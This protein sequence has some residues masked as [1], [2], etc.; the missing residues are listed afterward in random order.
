MYLG[1]HV[2]KPTDSHLDNYLCVAWPCSVMW[3]DWTESGIR[4][5]AT[6]RQ[7]FYDKFGRWPIVVGRD[8]ER[9][10]NVLDPQFAINCIRERDSQVGNL[11]D[12][13]QV[14][15]EPAAT[16]P[17]ELKAINDFYCKVIDGLPASCSPI[18]VGSLG[19]GN[20]RNII[21]IQLLEPAI[22]KAIATG[23]GFA[24]HEY[25]Q[26]RMDNEA[27]W[28][29]GRLLKTLD[30]LSIWIDKSKL[31]IFI[32]ECG[33][34]YG[35]VVQN[36]PVEKYT[37]WVNKCSEDDYVSQLR[38]FKE[39]YRQYPQVIACHI[40]GLA[41]EELWRKFEIMGANKVANLVYESAVEFANN[42]IQVVTPQTVTQRNKMIYLALIPSNQDR[43][44]VVGGG[45]EKAQ[46]DT[47]AGKML[48]EANKYVNVTAKV[49]NGAPESKD[50]APL[51][52]LRAQQRAAKA[53]LDTFSNENA[54]KIAL[55][56]HTDSGRFTHLFSCYW[57][58]GHSQ[59]LGDRI[60]RAL[61]PIF[62]TNYLKS[63]DYSSYV[64]VTEQIGSPCTPLLLELGSH[65]MVSDTSV[66]ANRSPEVANTILQAIHSYFGIEPKMKTV[67]QQAGP[68]F[69]DLKYYATWSLLRCN[70]KEEPRSAPDF[71]KHC[72]AIGKMKDIYEYGFPI[73]R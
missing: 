55:N 32:T 11:V 65:E 1:I 42:K 31:K 59:A 33:I 56:F 23:G 61:G 57:N 25:S 45:N 16:S 46:M 49:F 47:F 30:A 54:I 6:Y 22:Q 8:G 2:E 10:S 64:F 26:P 73:K 71:E 60:I 15:N 27:G 34:D 52:G 7:R 28:H 37:G 68:N 35:A 63:V 36:S 48:A 50:I 21:D 58:Q 43:N 40:F 20:P 29:C 19:E 67:E 44:P 72:R 4:I 14:L 12:Y 17:E 13:W 38:W 39:L 24:V 69:E 70:N 18:L 53:W 62:S 9:I 3:M 5:L 66:I 41:T 51:S